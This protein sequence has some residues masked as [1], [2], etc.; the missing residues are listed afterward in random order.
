MPFDYTGSRVVMY[1]PITGLPMQYGSTGPDGYKPATPITPFATSQQSGHTEYVVVCQS[2]TSGLIV[3]EHAYDALVANSTTTWSW[4]QWTGTSNVNKSTMA[5]PVDLVSDPRPT[6]SATVY[7]YDTSGYIWKNV[8]FSSNGTWSNITPANVTGG[9]LVPVAPYQPYNLFQA[10]A[11]TN[12]AGSASYMRYMTFDG[13]GTLYAL[14]FR[15][16]SSA[17]C[18][19][20]VQQWTGA[21][22]AWNDIT[23]GNATVEA[24]SFGISNNV[25]FGV[26]SSVSG[27]VILSSPNVGTSGNSWIAYNY[28]GGSWGSFVSQPTGYA[29]A[30]ATTATSVTEQ[31]SVEASASATDGYETIKLGAGVSA[32]GS[33]IYNANSGDIYNIGGVSAEPTNAISVTLWPSRSPT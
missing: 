9:K 15:T 13:S 4:Y 11:T 28:T 1:N 5:Y 6:V 29:L 12:D 19:L 21:G 20:S 27:N 10:G 31:Y 24:T 25:S 17:N 33:L 32:S 2:P 26:F 3:M 16:I 14:Y 30:Q 23:S 18:Y 8:G 22:T 7:T